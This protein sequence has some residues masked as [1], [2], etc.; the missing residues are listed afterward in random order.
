[1]KL[2][3]FETSNPRKPCAVAKYLDL[4]V[5][6]IRIDLFKGEQ[7]TPEFLALNPNG[8]VPVLVDGDRRI[9][10][11]DAIMCYLADHTGSDLWPH[12]ARQIEVISWLAWNIAHFSRHAGTLLFENHIRGLA[13]M[14]EPNA[15]NIADA[16]GFFRRFAAVLED[17]LAGRDHLVGDALTVA[18]FAV[19]SILP[20]AKEAKLPLAE[21]PE[22]RRWHAT[23]EQLPAW[24]DP[25]P[26]RAAAA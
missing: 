24:R 11:S 7:K 10:E 12:D 9:W 5:E 4:P 1:M 19:A 20:S 25:F 14:G 3:Y 22:I 23:L 13:G 15:A 8:K 18:D 26:E 21:F 6:Y 2:Y 16:E 17:H